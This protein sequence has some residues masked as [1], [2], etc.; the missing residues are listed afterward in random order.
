MSLAQ[1]SDVTERLNEEGGPLRVFPSGLH[2]D[3]A[4]HVWKECDRSIRT[5]WNKLDSGK[6]RA[7]FVH[8]YFGPDAEEE[9]Y[10]TMRFLNWIHSHVN[11]A[12]FD[13]ECAIHIPS[14]KQA[15]EIWL[16]YAHNRLYD[17]LWLCRRGLPTEAVQALREIAAREY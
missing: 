1:F 12:T 11:K 5:L 4:H 13:S 9:F 14:P 8:E 3:Y 2:G 7:L 17:G 10:R 15:D 16:E 6:R